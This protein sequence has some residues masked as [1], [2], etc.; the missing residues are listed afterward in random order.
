[1]YDILLYGWWSD[2]VCFVLS[3]WF[4][5]CFF[6]FF[7]LIYPSSTRK[8]V[9]PKMSEIGR[10]SDLNAIWHLLQIS[11]CHSWRISSQKLIPSKDCTTTLATLIS[12]WNT[13]K[14]QSQSS[15]YMTHFVGK[16]C[17]VWVFLRG[18]H[19]MHVAPKYSQK[20]IFTHLVY[21]K[22]WMK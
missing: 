17:H 16:H 8:G 7:I 14:P 18:I 19:C 5:V 12:C 22:I 21:I 1:M 15:L 2:K 10:A 6:L 9:F 13:S 20:I 4:L 3:R 11:W